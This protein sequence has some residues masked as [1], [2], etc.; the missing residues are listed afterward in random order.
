M[1]S[2]CEKAS[3]ATGHP[4]QGGE[5]KGPVGDQGEHLLQLSLPAPEAWTADITMEKSTPMPTARMMMTAGTG[6]SL[7]LNSWPTMLALMKLK[8]RKNKN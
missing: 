6:L 8:R 1:K 5:G 7:M 3:M 2:N 4:E